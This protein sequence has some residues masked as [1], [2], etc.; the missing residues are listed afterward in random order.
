MP[1][2]QLLIAP[3]LLAPLRYTPEAWVAIL[4]GVVPKVIEDR[5]FVF[6]DGGRIFFHRSWTGYCVYVA[7]ME[8]GGEY[9][10]VT[11]LGVN[12]DPEQ[13]GGTDNS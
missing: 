13:Y 12:R 4:R 1:A 10:V 5:W 8:R 7:D 9:Y 6:S 11:R 2:S 3:A